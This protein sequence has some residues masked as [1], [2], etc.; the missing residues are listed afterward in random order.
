MASNLSRIRDALSA[1]GTLTDEQLDDFTEEAARMVHAQ[2]QFACSNFKAL[3]EN[4]DEYLTEAFLRQ[5]T[6]AGLQILSV[7]P[8][9]LTAEDLADFPRIPAAVSFT[10]SRARGVY[11]ILA[12]G[13][14]EFAL[15]VGSSGWL[16][17]R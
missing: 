12:E 8:S 3:L 14:Q 11:I 4:D 10:G 2:R 17:V 7:S 1:N 13:V 15:K 6:P 5:L 9:A 16:E